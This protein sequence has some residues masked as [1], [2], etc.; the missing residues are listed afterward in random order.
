M[1]RIM[2]NKPMKSDIC[3][4]YLQLSLSYFIMLD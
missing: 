4:I 3:M 1:P 2:V